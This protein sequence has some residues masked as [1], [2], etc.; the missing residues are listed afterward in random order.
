LKEQNKSLETVPEET[1]ALDLL[2]KDFNIAVLHTLEELKESIE[3]PT[4]IRKIVHK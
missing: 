4:K 1:E 3:E 2:A